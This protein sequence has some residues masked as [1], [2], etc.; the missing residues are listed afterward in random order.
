MTRMHYILLYDLVPDYLTRR[1]QFRDSH[2]A[3]ARRA[4]ERGD[5]I[6]AGALVDPAD[7]AILIF[8]GNSPKAPE[9][10]ALNDP[11][12]KN[13]LVTSWSVRKWNTVV[14]EGSSPP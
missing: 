5:L 7:R 1:A 11:Y 3:H 2:L 9:E 8:S 14:G 12:V 4:F 13:G 10:F 6:L